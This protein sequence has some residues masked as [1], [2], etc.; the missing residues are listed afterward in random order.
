MTERT[1]YPLEYRLEVLKK[2]EAWADVKNFSQPSVNTGKM[3]AEAV[4]EVF[5][6]NDNEKKDGS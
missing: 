5:C 2:I 4:T 6:H 1:W 3:L